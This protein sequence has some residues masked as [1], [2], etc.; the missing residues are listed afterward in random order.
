MSELFER[1]V[2]PFFAGLQVPVKHLF[3]GR[4]MHLGGI[5]DHAVQ[6]ENYRVEFG[7]EC[8]FAYFLGFKVS[9]FV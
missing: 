2:K 4:S 7:S 8:H 6:V 5:R 9:I 3:P 1:F